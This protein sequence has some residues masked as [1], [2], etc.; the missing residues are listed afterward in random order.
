MKNT[1][2]ILV[3]IY[4]ILFFNFGLQAQATQN[5]TKV[6]DDYGWTFYLRINNYTVNSAT[7][8][9]A[10]SVNN[11]FFINRLSGG[12][13]AYTS[14]SSGNFT[15]NGVDFGFGVRHGRLFKSNLLFSNANLRD[16]ESTA[17]VLDT[18]NTYSFFG[19]SNISINATSLSQYSYAN[20]TLQT[21]RISYVGEFFPFHSLGALLS[22]LGIRIGP[23][24]YANGLKMK[25][26]Y[27][28]YAI[29][30]SSTINSTVVPLSTTSLDLVS[31]DKLTYNEGFG[32]VVIGLSYALDIK[33]LRI[34][35][36]ADYFKSLSSE[37]NYKS[38]YYMF[39][40]FP[41][42][43]KSKGSFNTDLSGYRLLFGFKY[44]FLENFG[45]RFSAGMTE[46]MHNVK[47]SKFK[48]GSG[49]SIN[50]IFSLFSGNVLPIL[51]SSQ[52]G[53]GP[54]PSSIDKRTQ[55]GFEFFLRF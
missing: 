24:L 18:I 16:S 31:Q 20:N 6:D 35:L 55:V 48:D 10:L 17:L 44:Q 22:K 3:G 14:P 30:G 43:I 9:N 5:P 50:A 46:A 51:L 2:K 15:G 13:I 42:E 7:A 4:I 21:G 52:P 36:T 54:N 19:S 26:P 38:S 27:N 47:N 34:D 29:S 39:S 1:N 25:S 49:T 8:N 40:I 23:E 41:T 53:F 45:M 37:G 28:V 11:A 12:R 32:N 33:N